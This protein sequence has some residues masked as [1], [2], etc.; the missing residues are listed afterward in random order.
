M[1]SMLWVSMLSVV[2]TTGACKKK[3]DDTDKAAS[4]VKKSVEEANDQKKDFDKTMSDKSATPK[5]L[6]KAN[7][8]LGAAKVDVAA[9]K[10]KYAIT[11]K[12]RLAKIDLKI[13][14]LE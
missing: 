1:R 7:T 11:V 13:R 4:E 9:A 8:D 10:D 12:D 2:L 6:D 14:E 5:D 3:Q